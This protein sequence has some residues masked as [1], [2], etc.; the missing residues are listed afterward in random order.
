MKRRVLLFAHGLPHTGAGDVE[1][2]AAVRVQVQDEERG[3]RSLRAV[4]DAMQLG[5]LSAGYTPQPFPALLEAIEQELGADDPPL[6]ARVPSELQLWIQRN[7]PRTWAKLVDSAQILQRGEAFVLERSAAGLA[8][9]RRPD[10]V[11]SAIDLSCPLLVLCDALARERIPGVSGV[12]KKTADLEDARRLVRQVLVSRWITRRLSPGLVWEAA[13]KSYRL[14]SEPDGPRLTE[15]AWANEPGVPGTLSLELPG[16]VQP[17][18]L[19]VDPQD[20]LPLVVVR[21]G[22]GWLLDP[23]RKAETLFLDAGGRRPAERS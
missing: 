22:I 8:I 3:L 11:L 10:G 15:T 23:A 18:E 5:G 20:D 17:F 12:V 7:A 21:R 9:T 14:R 2:S 1:F 13:A 6:E 4:P 19:D 16:S